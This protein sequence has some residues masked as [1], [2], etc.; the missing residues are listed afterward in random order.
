M[1][2]PQDQP[3][4]HARRAQLRRGRPG[5]P[6]RLR[7]RGVRGQRRDGRGGGHRPPLAARRRSGSLPPDLREHA[8]PRARGLLPHPRVAQAGL[9]PA[10]GRH[11]DPDRRR[12]RAAGRGRPDRHEGLPLRRRRPRQ[13]G[14][15]RHPRGAR[16][17]G[18]GVPREADGRGG[19]GLRRADG[20]LPRGPGDLTRGVRLRAQGGSH[21][22]HDLPRH[23]WRRHAQPGLGPPPRRPGR[24]SPLA[25]QGGRRPRRP[26]H[27]RAHRGRRDGG[28]RVQ[29]AGRHLRGAD[30]PLPRLPGGDEARLPGP[31][32]PHPP[33]GAHRPAAGAP[34]QG[35]RPGRRVRA[36]RHRRGG[37]AQ[38]DPRRRR[39][40]REGRRVG[41]QD[42]GPAAPGDGVRHGAKGQG[43]RGEGVRRAAAPPGG[44]PHDRRAPRPPDRRGDRGGA[45]PDPRRGDRRP[46]E[47]ALRRRGEPQAAAGAL[48]RDHPGPGQGAWP[49]Q[50]ADRRPRPVRRLP[51]RD[52]AAA[53]R[54][55]GS[56]S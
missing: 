29:D 19:R 32:L 46:D 50:E 45:H 10:R 2:G 44:G 18:S 56:S 4:R 38:G 26:G 13:L 53:R 48:P 35:V 3:D 8:R 9:R 25:G 1:A 43:R 15:D 27:P 40:G 54:G 42:A 16:R 34:G 30:Q 24:G 12:A 49:L 51:H 21:R 33:Q 31:E 23:L 36:R 22:R 17:A 11:R 37:Q 7:G 52:R 47:G 14:G 5:R 20:A 41:P 28:V 55:A 39:A 6:A